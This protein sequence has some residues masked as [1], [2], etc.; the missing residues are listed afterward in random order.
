MDMDGTIT[1]SRQTISPKMKRKLKSLKQPII[2]VSGA[3]KQRILKQ[4]DGV[5]CVMMAQNGNDAPNWQ[6]TL[7]KEEKYEI[8]EHLSNFTDMLE[9]YVHDRGCQISFS[10]TG[11]HAP[12]KVKQDFDPDKKFRNKMLKKYP[13]KSQTLV[14]RV[15]GTTCFDYNKKGNLKGDNLKR[16]MKLHNLDPKECVYYG[17]NFDKGGNDESVLGVMRCVKVKSPDDLYKKLC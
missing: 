12:T 14:V 3:E 7:T 11:H 15:A 6:N 4:M 17:D 2:V 8:H 13:F 9:D 1:E 10:W 16:Y 5:P